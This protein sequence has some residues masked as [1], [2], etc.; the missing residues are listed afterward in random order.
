MKMDFIM[1]RPSHK[2][3]NGKLQAALEFVHAN[4]I[5]LVEPEAIVND[6]TILGYSI[7]HEL[8]IVLLDLLNNT[9][10]E[11]YAGHQPPERSYETLIRDLELW[12]FSVMC[13]RLSS[14]IYYK[15]YLYGK[16]FY[17]VSLHACTSQGK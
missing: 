3:L 4:R 10:P 15:F 16:T 5:K 17:L 7:E 2:E 13:T 12:T 11:H 1:V 8:Q 6:A 14:R 9:G